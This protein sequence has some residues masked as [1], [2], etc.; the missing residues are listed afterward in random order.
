M[1]LL[2]KECML[3]PWELGVEYLILI[4]LVFV[5]LNELR[6]YYFRC[7]TCV[8]FIWKLLSIAIETW[9]KRFMEFCFGVFTEFKLEIFVEFWAWISTVTVKDSFTH[10]VRIRSSLARRLERGDRW[11]ELPFLSPLGFKI[12]E[13]SGGELG[14]SFSGLILLACRRQNLT[15][16]STFVSIVVF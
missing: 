1:S 12:L 15:D 10:M 5:V 14:R 3:C 9:I 8:T 11:I 16:P 4:K 13:F 7:I 6:S 2:G